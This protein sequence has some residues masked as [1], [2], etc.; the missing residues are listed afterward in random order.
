MQAK[1]KQLEE[2]TARGS[3][4]VKKLQ[5]KIEDINDLTAD[6]SKKVSEKVSTGM[7]TVAISFTNHSNHDL[8]HSKAHYRLSERVQT[9]I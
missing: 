7:V 1:N 4:A 6:P 5:K 9:A 8:H 2:K 3:E